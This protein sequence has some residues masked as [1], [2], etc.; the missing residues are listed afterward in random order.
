MSL[1]E[2]INEGIRTA[3]KAKN[4]ADLRSYRAIKAAIMLAK[5]APDYKGSLT[6]AD[7]AKLLQKLA[8]QRKDSLDIYRQQKR[9]DLARI[10]EEELAVI[11]GFLPSRLSEEELRARLKEIIASTGASSPADMGKVMGV[12]SR[13][14]AGRAD[15]KAIAALVKDMLQ[16]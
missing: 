16:H 13:E 8:K 7:E 9:E 12:A 11:E 3:M 6:D 2:K 10:E 5:T 15:G 1:E 14:L 4:E